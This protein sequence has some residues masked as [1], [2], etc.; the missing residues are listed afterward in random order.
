MGILGGKETGRAFDPPLCLYPERDAH[1][2][3]LDTHPTDYFPAAY[4]LKC[5]ATLPA[6]SSPMWK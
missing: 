5:S 2:G 4:S 6:F 3:G 1:S